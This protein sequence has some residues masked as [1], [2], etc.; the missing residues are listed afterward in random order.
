MCDFPRFKL[1]YLFLYLLFCIMV[2]T[3]CVAPEQ[4][5]PT[6]ISTIQTPSTIETPQLIKTAVVEEI[7]TITPTSTYT[8]IPTLTSFPTPTFVPATATPTITPVATLSVQEEGVFLSTLMANNN[9]CELPCWWGIMPG[10][11]ENQVARDLFASQ[12]ID[13]WI[14]S[15]DGTY[16]I[17]NLGY[18]YG[19]SPYYS[20]DIIVQFWVEDGLIEFINVE[21]SRRQAEDKY[22][23]TQNWQQ[24]N[25]SQILRRFGM[26]SYV[27]LNPEVSADSGTFFYQL[28]LSYPSLGIEVSYI[29]EPSVLVNGSRQICSDFEQVNY[30]Y[31]TLFP[32]ERVADV[33]VA[34]I[35]NH[36]EAYLSWE[37]V[38]ESTL[39]I[40]YEMFQ[41]ADVPTCIEV[42]INSS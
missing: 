24:Y 8:P 10:K 28:G 33:P 11:T 5:E 36:T 19:D 31:L 9:N 38:T 15:F 25:L 1:S 35:P 30:I 39:E 32:P 17:L 29:I 18:P 37:T 41:D 16:R 42:D 13:E 27:I 34:I 3:N 21:G 4:Q 40:F 12:G 2:Q 20:S 23:F 7:M 26:P 14:S 22:L 6:V